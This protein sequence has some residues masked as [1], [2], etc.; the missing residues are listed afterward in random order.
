[1]AR[2]GRML[3]A[4]VS[5][6][7]FDALTSGPA[8]AAEIAAALAAQDRSLRILLDGL[9]ALELL[10]KD[11]AGRYSHT[12]LSRKYLAADAPRSLAS[13]LKYQDLLAPAWADLAEIVRR[14][15]PTRPLASLLHGQSD[16]T[17]QYIRGMEEIAKRP[18]AEIAE[19]LD[20][21]HMRDGLDVGGGPGTYSRTFAERSSG[22]KMVLLDLEPTL[23]VTAEIL[24]DSGVRGRIDLR[25]GDYHAADFG[26]EMFDLVLLSHI[27]HDEGEA[28]NRKLLAKAFAALRPGGYVVI[29]DFMLDSARTSP[30]FGALFSVHLMV[31]T[32]QGRTFS[33]EEYEQWL[34]GCGFGSLRRIEICR[35]SP[36]ATQAIIAEKP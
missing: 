6:G 10:N 19:H 3:C 11:E 1:M 27:T 24:R 34:S 33:A 26:C 12:A 25:P 22:L 28:D 23:A 4:A 2:A 21:A 8:S 32:Q 15:E 9:V 17:R 7:V 5:L 16:F 29:H 31:Y 13:N 14:G 20:L 35:G 30:L 36:N 18:A